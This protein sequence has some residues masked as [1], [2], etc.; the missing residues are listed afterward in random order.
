MSAVWR[1]SGVQ[2]ALAPRTESCALPFEESVIAVAR[3]REGRKTEEDS[4]TYVWCVSRAEL[5]DIDGQ[6]ADAQDCLLRHRAALGELS[7]AAELESLLLDF[8]LDLEMGVGRWA[9]RFPVELLEDLAQLRAH[10][11]LSAY[12]CLSE[13][14]ESPFEEEDDR[15][16]C[17]DRERASFRLRFEAEPGPASDHAWSLLERRGRTTRNCEDEIAQALEAQRA[18]VERLRSERACTRAE[19]HIEWSVPSGLLG[20]WWSFP[21]DLLRSCAGLGLDLRVVARALPLE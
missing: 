19:L 1:A 12:L 4:T 5:T 6:V 10:L 17:W 3:R 13:E 9:A 2:R 18:R 7:G 15:E 14:D 11:C 16:A 21:P 20:P 8:G